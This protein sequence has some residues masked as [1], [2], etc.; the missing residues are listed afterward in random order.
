M[1]TESAWL[2]DDRDDQGAPCLRLGKKAREFL[3]NDKL[4]S[5]EVGGQQQDGHSRTFQRLFN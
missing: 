1:T 2:H 4:R 5:Q 3:V